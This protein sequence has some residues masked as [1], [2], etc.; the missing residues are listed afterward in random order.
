MP[1]RKQR[2][3]RRKKIRPPHRRVS[4]ESTTAPPS[5]PTEAESSERAPPSTPTGPTPAPQTPSSSSASRKKLSKAPHTPLST[6][7]SSSDDEPTECGNKLVILEIDGLNETLKGSVCCKEC[8]G[9]PVVLVQDHT[10]KEG[11]STHPSLQCEQ[12]GATNKIPFSTL[13]PS[14]KALTINRKSVFAN[15]CIGSTSASLNTFCTMM[16]LPAPVSQKQYREHAI[17]IND[18]C[19]AEAQDSMRRARQEVRKCYDAAL[20]DVIDVTVSSDGTWQ[21]RGFS[22]LFGITFIIEHE[23]KKVLDYE[24][25]SKFCAACKRWENCDQE[26]DEFKKWREEHKGVCEANFTG[27]AGA[28]EPRGISRMFSRSLDFNVRYKYL[29]SDGDAKTHALLLEEKP[30]GDGHDVEKVDCVGHVQK[31]MGTALRELKKQYRGQKLSDGKTIGGAGRLTE[32]VINSLQ[33]YYGDAIRRHTGDLPGMMKAVQAS[34]MHYNSTDEHP[35]H[36]LCPEGETSWCKWQKAKAKGSVYTHKKPPLPAPIVKLLQPIYNRLGSAA[37]LERCLGG[38]TQNPNESLHSTVWK[39][40]PKELFLGRMAVDTASAIAVCR[41]NDGA[42]SLYDVSRRLQLEPSPMCKV[43]LQLKDLQRVEKADYKASGHYKHL[44]KTAR[45]KRKG[46]EDKNQEEE[47]VMYSS[48]AFD[49][50]ESQ[51]GP[52]KKK[53]K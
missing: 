42:S 52:S 21:R 16:D 11:L 8:S 39:L 45:A 3:I 35:R 25:M 47:G 14:H 38:Y 24:V 46:Y 4:Q 40:C 19:I 23:T 10:R 13:P 15:K 17:V 1:G 43:Q 36:H 7:T 18:Q 44:R 27:S 28:M 30:Y 31:R 49:I 32:S 48:G 20:G 51:A 6:V 29:I 9:G 33:N 34:L 50:P 37:L 22:S 26:G 12:C 2:T 5:A 41:F 53:K